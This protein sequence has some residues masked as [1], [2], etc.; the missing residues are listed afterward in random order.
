MLES[1]RI[2]RGK[3]QNLNE[4]NVDEFD[5]LAIPGGM[6]ALKNLGHSNEMAKVI[7]A[8]HA[9]EKPIAAICIAPM[10]L[11]QTIGAKGITI[12]L[13]ELGPAAL[14]AQKLG[15]H[16]EVCAVDDFITDRD[17]RIITTPA[18][19][20]SEASPLRSLLGFAKRFANSWRCLRSPGFEGLRVRWL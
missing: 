14:E 12:T 15:V 3:I 7:K 16:H 17:H 2:A 11:A 8:F 13:G 6:G 5:G 18:Y 10:L 4:L 9:N 19:M 1:A 20:Y